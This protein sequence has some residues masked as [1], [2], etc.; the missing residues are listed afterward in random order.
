MGFEKFGVVSHM[1]ESKAAEFVDYLE[2][3]KVMVTRCR[4][5][6]TRSFPPKVDCPK[7]LISDMEWSEITGSGK[8]IT[9]TVVNYGPAGFEDK[10]PYILAV[11]E[12]E[13]GLKVFAT[14]SK[15]IKES[16]VAPG[17]ALKVVPIALP[18]EKIS[19]EFQAA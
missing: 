10:A 11:A 2:Q 8:L 5:C 9:Y 14:L 7:C 1:K 17:M 15:D 13:G 3:G 6:G 19:Y 12:F 4:K 16:D 18:E